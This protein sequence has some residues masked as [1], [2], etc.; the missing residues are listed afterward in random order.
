MVST[1]SI[2]CPLCMDVLLDTMKQGN[3]TDTHTHRH[4]SN[5]NQLLNPAGVAEEEIFT[6]SSSTP[7]AGS[8]VGVDNRM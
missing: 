1:L 6:V 7:G 2:V 5:G 8:K 4:T 3:N